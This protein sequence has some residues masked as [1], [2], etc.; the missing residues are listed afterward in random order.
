MAS[1]LNYGDAVVIRRVMNDYRTHD[2]I[3][4]EYPQPDSSSQG[5]R[6]IQRL[7]GL[8]GDTIALSDKALLINGI[9]IPDTSSLQFNYFI[10]LK[11]KEADSLFR[12]KYHFDEGGAVSNDLD[13]SYSLNHD[14]FVQL[15][16][17][18]LIK[19]IELKHE[20]SKNYDETCF[21]GYPQ[22]C[23]NRDFYGPVRIPRSNDTLRLDTLNIGLYS[24]LIRDYERNTLERRHDSI[25]IN[26]RS[27]AY[28]VPRLNYYFVLG[29]NRDNANDSRVWGFLPE[30]YIKGR[31]MFTLRKAQP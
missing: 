22:F 4:F 29:D 13:Y 8:P 7:I 25:F 31:V 24:T 27:T 30:H 10:T 17:D 15:E 3:Y 21:P 14:E 2:L 20:K 23:W 18:S 28:Y 16:K 26:G 6:F 1:T 19:K 5:V 12:L 11:N 9:T